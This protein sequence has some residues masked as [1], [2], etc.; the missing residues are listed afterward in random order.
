M[1]ILSLHR[2]DVSAVQF[3]GQLRSNL[4]QRGLRQQAGGSWVCGAGAGE[5]GRGEQRLALNRSHS[6]K[7]CPGSVYSPRLGSRSSSL[8]V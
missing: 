5:F 1:Q 7:Q 4:H 6:T 3:L 8:M 2:S